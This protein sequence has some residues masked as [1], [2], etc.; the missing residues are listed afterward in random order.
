MCTP[1]YTLSVIIFVENSEKILIRGVQVKVINEKRVMI[2]DETENLC[3]D[4]A[5]SIIN[6]LFDE[7]F[8]EEGD[9]ITCEI[10]Q[11]GD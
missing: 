2:L 1:F 6:Y 3:E 4:E 10:V 8:I 9:E 7:G 5:T 11:G